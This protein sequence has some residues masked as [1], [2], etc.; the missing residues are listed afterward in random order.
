MQTCKEINTFIQTLYVETNT[1]AR[2][3]DKNGHCMWKRM[4]V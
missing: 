4:I 1:L 2:L 3:Y